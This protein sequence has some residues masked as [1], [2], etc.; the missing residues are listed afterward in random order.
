[1][2]WKDFSIMIMGR[3]RQELNE[4]ARTRNLAYIVYLSSTAD[5]NPKSLT[6]FWHIPQIDDLEVEDNK[7]MISSDQLSK[8]L[9]LYEVI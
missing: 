2:T 9:K 5:N 7:E 3:E 4:W 6:S 8:T 1:M